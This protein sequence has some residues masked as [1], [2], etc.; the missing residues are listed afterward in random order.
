MLSRIT[1]KKN[2]WLRIANSERAAAEQQP[3]IAGTASS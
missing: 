1:T 3:E 2:E